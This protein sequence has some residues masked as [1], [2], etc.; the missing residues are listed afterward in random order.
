MS[1]ALATATFLLLG[2]GQY[3]D[4]SPWGDGN[5]V[6][7]YRPAFTPTALK[8]VQPKYVGI[9]SR[10]GIQ[11]INPIQ[12]HYV[13][14]KPF[15]QI[16]T[17]ILKELTPDR[18]LRYLTLEQ[19][20]RRGSAIGNKTFPDRILKFWIRDGRP[21]TGSSN[22]GREYTGQ[23]TYTLI[24]V[25]E[26]PLVVGP[27]PR[28]WP[29][30][31]SKANPLPKTF[32]GLP[33]SGFA[34]QPDMWAKEIT[35]IGESAYYVVWI[36]PGKAETMA[37]KLVDRFEALPGWARANSR[38]ADSFRVQPA[39]GRTSQIA[40]VSLNPGNYSFDEVSAQGW[41]CI[42]MV[43]A[44]PATGLWRRSIVPKKG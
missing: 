2:A 28:H 3:S 40:Y 43:W 25:S 42:S 13:V 23:G 39:N 41:T 7:G 38:R 44:D 10:R 36:V 17:S 30:V 4:D 5:H 19:I 15:A 14:K 27:K 34:K 9:D 12:S 8:G 6:P 29:K 16:A 11:G 18:D 22:R 20:G 26:R 33:I 37:P 1:I 31:A 32:P 21:T 35:P 24:T